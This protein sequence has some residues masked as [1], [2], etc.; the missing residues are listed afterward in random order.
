MSKVTIVDVAKL[1]HRLAEYRDENGMEVGPGIYREAAI[2]LGVSPE[3]ADE[4]AK[5]LED[6]N[7]RYP[8][9][10]RVERWAQYVLDMSRG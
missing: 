1:A 10:R 2:Q 5:G 9:N 4:W 8:G 6:T 7:T 3:I